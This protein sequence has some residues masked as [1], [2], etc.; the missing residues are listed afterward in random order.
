MPPSVLT[1][2]AGSSSI[3]FALFDAVSSP[4]LQLNGEI[5]RVGQPGSTIKWKARDDSNSQR[6]PVE[7]TNREGSLAPLMQLLKQQ[8]GFDSIHGVGHRIVHGGPDYAEPQA[9][10]PQVIS[11]LRRLSPL[12]PKHLP[13][14]IELIESCM[15]SLPGVPQVV[16]FDTAFHHDLPRRARL[17]PVPL[18]YETQGIRRYGFHGLS[19]SF[20]LGEVARLAGGDAAR[21]RIILAHLGSGASMAAVHEGRSIDTTMAFTPA[22]GLV[23]GTRCGDI[24]PGFLVYVMRSQGANAQTIDDLVNSQSG[25]LGLSETSGDM[26]DLMDRE[27]SDPRAHDAIEVFCYQAKKW[28]GGLS[29]ALGGLDLLVFSGGIGENSPQVRTRICQGLEFLGIRLDDAR[30]E[31]GADL[32]S[33]D[34]A[35]VAVRVIRTDEEL[36]IARAVCAIL[37]LADAS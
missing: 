6:R 24:D 23:M 14:E 36:V 13:A 8:I 30:N 29:A 34:A 16:C 17:L 28:I 18:R 9:V 32:I 19:Y 4:T 10:T 20:L 12:D 1:I 11:E 31:H 3:K 35:P 37:K 7:G 2:N 21:G 5:E 22:A 15:R 25:L 26:R 33:L 27:K